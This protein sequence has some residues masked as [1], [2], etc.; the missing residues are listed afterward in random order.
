MSFFFDYIPNV[1][2][3]LHLELRE[4]S[5]RIEDHK[6]PNKSQDCARSDLRCLIFGRFKCQIFESYDVTRIRDR[7]RFS[8]LRTENLAIWDGIC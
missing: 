2:Q 5:S 3:N 6:R 7:R 8:L 1:T 4:K